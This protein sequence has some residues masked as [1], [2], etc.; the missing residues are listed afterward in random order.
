MYLT[1]LFP[2]HGRKWQS[3]LFFATN[4]DCNFYNGEQKVNLI[5]THITYNVL[6]KDI[7]SKMIC[8]KHNKFIFRDYEDCPDHG[9]YSFFRSELGDLET[10]L[11]N[12]K[13]KLK[14]GT[15]NINYDAAQVLQSLSSIK[16]AAFHPEVLILNT[17][18]K[19]HSPKRIV[20]PNGQDGM[21]CEECGDFYP[22]VLPNKKNAYYCPSH[23]HI[24]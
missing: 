13:T 8:S 15:L 18:D 9:S 4:D 23:K 10:L 5:F 2:N 19:L 21:C 6:E 12:A 16:D 11:H 17:I 20:M 7:E 3:F 22:Y 24:E 1:D 14:I